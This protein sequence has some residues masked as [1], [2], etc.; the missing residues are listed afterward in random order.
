MGYSRV[1]QVRKL[2]LKALKEYNEKSLK[3]FKEAVL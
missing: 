2:R 3:H 1:V